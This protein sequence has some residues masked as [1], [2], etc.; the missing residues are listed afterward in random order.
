MILDFIN[1]IMPELLA[2]LAVTIVWW[3]RAGIK[4]WLPKLNEYI[5]AHVSAQTQQVILELGAEAFSYAETVYRH[6]GG[7]EKL[8]EAIRYFNE[9]MN[10][11]GLSNLTADAIRA[12]IEKAWLEDKRKE[13][14]APAELT[15]IEMYD[16]RI[17]NTI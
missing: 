10:R 11:Y 16:P 17:E 15:E 7:A 13:Q 5:D 12:A 6:K 4:T 1:G 2:L 14:L 3:V 8:S 9:N